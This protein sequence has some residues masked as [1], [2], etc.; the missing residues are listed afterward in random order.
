[1][2]NGRDEDRTKTDHVRRAPRHIRARRT[3]DSDF[4]VSLGLFIFYLM[5]LALMTYYIASFL[6]MDL[7]GTL[8]GPGFINLLPRSQRKVAHKVVAAHSAVC[9]VTNRHSH[10]L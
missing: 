10:H 2:I 5:V 7:V 4:G 8:S 6:S 9:L 3:R 1:M